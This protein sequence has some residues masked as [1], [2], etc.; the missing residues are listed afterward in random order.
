M[1]FQHP[2]MLWWLFVL[3]IPII[4]HLFNFRR[5]KMILFS[6]IELLRN[7]QEQTSNTNKL[8]HLVV[9]F[10]RLLALL[11]LV[12]AFAQ[13]YFPNNN[14]SSKQEKLVSI[15][16][17]NSISMQLRGSQMTLLEEAK[18][19]A[20][21][22]T[23]KFGLSVRYRLITND[24]E[25][26]WNKTM[27]KAELLNAL[28]EIKI[29]PVSL[30]FGD[31]IRRNQ[32]F[33]DQSVEKEHFMFA[34][35]DF[36]SS[37]TQWE[38]LPNDTSL[39]LFL[40]P[41]RP[42]AASNL[43]I[44]SIWLDGPVLQQGMEVH[45]N[46]NVVNQG[47]ERAL[48]IPV[49][50]ELNGASVAVTNLDVEAASSATTNLQFLAPDAG[51]H[52]GKV[53][54]QDYPIV[55]DDEMLFSFAI[56]PKLHA[57]EIYETKHDPWIALLFDEKTEIELTHHQRLQLDYEALSQYQLI[58]LNQLEAMP[59]GMV[60]A[61]QEFVEAGGSL[62]LLPTEKGRN[63]Y[64]LLLQ[65]HGF[66]YQ[67]A[68]T[69][70]T[71]VFAVADKHP[72]FDKVFVKIPENADL[73]TVH[74]HFPIQLTENSTAFAL[75]RLL[76]GS[77]FLVLHHLP[78]GGKIYGL[79]VAYD[80][81]QSNFVKNNLFVPVNYR[82]LLMASSVR[83]LYYVAQNELEIPF[84]IPPSIGETELRVVDDQGLFSF[85]PTIDNAQGKNSFLLQQLL[86]GST[87]YNIIVNDSLKEVFSVNANRMESVLRFQTSE[88]LSAMKNKQMFKQV[89]VLD[90]LQGANE[91][92]NMASVDGK[93]LFKYFLVFVLLFLL[94]EAMVLRFWK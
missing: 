64:N 61:L 71:R 68:D 31:V 40:L 25:P 20:V 75:I 48:G 60:Q 17:D 13:P 62:V 83:P 70:K 27:D 26:R 36:Q 7:L 37:S 87:H 9:L 16:L 54:I 66:A 47:S 57:L 58:F 65:N 30:D 59:T 46:L 34:L 38:A 52:R 72:F 44:D 86:P 3:L 49:Q 4:V 45:L 39:R 23:D 32:A 89:E 18:E 21:A 15:Y 12:M 1:S 43:Y 41:A 77:P 92:V 81:K 93:Q 14:L 91:G 22:V 94:A 53:S 79:A 84:K 56:Q 5:H 69:A 6:N 90:A 63:D 50:L 85:F 24:F 82:M 80:E 28:E 10:L 33:S 73:P 19:R 11:L 42:G 74:K 55:F 35:S 76:N 29:S 8:K 51:L 67:A 78:G 2:S 88:E